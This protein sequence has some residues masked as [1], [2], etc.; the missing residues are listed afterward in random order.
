MR[1]TV[2]NLL[3]LISLAHPASAGTIDTVAGSGQSG[4][5]G[6]GGPARLASL[7][8]PFHCEFDR[9]GALLIADA[10]AGRIRRY[11]LGS[12]TITTLAGNGTNG[13][14]PDSAPA[15]EATI[16]TPYALA[17]DADGD[18]YF[19]DQKT[20]IVRKLDGKTGLVTILAGT[21][22]KGFG[23]D[24]G[25]ATK[26]L[27]RE[28]ND[29]CLDGHGGL[30]IA[31]VGDWRIR[32]V[33]LASGRISTFA[34][35]GK[36]AKRPDRSRIG[37]GGQAVNA[38][39]VGARAVCVDGLGSTYICEREGNAI[40]KVDSSGVI[41]TVAGTGAEGYSGDGGPALMANFRGPKAIRTDR[42]GNLLIVDTEN[43]AIRRINVAT[44]RIETVAGGHRGPDGDGGDAT[45]AGLNRPH[46]CIVGSDGTLYIA[47]SENHRVRAVSA[48]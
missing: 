24:G 34:G 7:I 22:T 47:D 10:P 26:A 35:T 39:I 38:I 6:D 28:P 17:A 21:G 37:N 18:V 41:T 11:D 42:S 27:L 5:T 15:L 31:D 3:L 9:G 48:R 16:G 19:V 46:G 30:L 2:G 14:G 12:G 43:H 23:G 1:P 40:R 36:P 45:Q 44:G 32:R 25:P 29:C 8:E 13:R 33:D 20:P 4:T